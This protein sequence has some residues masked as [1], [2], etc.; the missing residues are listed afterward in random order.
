MFWSQKSWREVNTLVERDAPTEPGTPVEQDAP[1][2][3][4][5]DILVEPDAP[6]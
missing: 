3:V 2:A 1:V 4:E 6:I 5:T